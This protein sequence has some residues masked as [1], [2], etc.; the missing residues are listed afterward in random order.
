MALPQLPL[1][2]VSNCMQRR[3]LVGVPKLCCR[4]CLVCVFPRNCTFLAWVARRVH[5]EPTC[6]ATP[7]LPPPTAT[8]SLVHC[9]ACVLAAVLLPLPLRR[10]RH[11]DRILSTHPLST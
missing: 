11:W 10:P 6:L 8:A 9:V 4:S 5:L 3:L 1:C 2:L 7:P